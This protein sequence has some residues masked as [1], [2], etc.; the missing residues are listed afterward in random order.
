MRRRWIAAVV[1]VFA[2]LSTPVTMA[3][4]DTGD[5]VRV[6]LQD[7]VHIGVVTNSGTAMLDLDVDGVPYTI[8]YASILE[9]ERS[10]GTR[11]RWLAGTVRGALWPVAIGGGVLI[12]CVAAVVALPPA[13]LLCIFLAGPVIAATLVAI[14]VGAVVGGII[15]A[16]QRVEMWEP[17]ALGA[18]QSRWTP[19][20][21]PLPGP[22]HGVRLEFGLRFSLW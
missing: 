3:A 17:V 21:L 22:G 13:V 2:L 20:L 7:T 5:R 16:H 18:R 12:G 6:S 15:G 14:P 10:T 19:T 8:D 11:T 9:L 4:Q 1:V